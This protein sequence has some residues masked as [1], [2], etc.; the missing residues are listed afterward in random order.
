MLMQRREAQRSK[1]EGK[2]QQPLMD[3]D[4]LLGVHDEQRLGALRFRQ[5]SDGPFL[6]DEADMA[7]PPWTAL[8]ELERAAWTVQS[9]T[10]DAKLDQSLRILLAPRFIDWWRKTQSGC[11]R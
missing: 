8:R 1:R 4:Y 3:S 9:D 7:A 11:H 2:P 10:S 5:L 6:S